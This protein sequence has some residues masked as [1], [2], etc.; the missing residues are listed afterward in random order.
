MKKDSKSMKAMGEL[1]MLRV[2]VLSLVAQERELRHPSAEL[3]NCCD[4][5]Q[6]LMQAVTDGFRRGNVVSVDINEWEEV[7]LPGFSR[8]VDGLVVPPDDQ[9]GELNDY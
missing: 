4:M 8:D 9:E 6:S 3:L 1:Y 2:K 5:L 7:M